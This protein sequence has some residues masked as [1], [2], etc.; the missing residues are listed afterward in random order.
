MNSTTIVAPAT[1]VGIGALAVVRISGPRTI[2]VLNRL[3]PGANIRRQPSHTLKLCWLKDKKGQP[4][5]QV[6]VALFRAPRSYTGEDMAEITCH[7]GPLIVDRIVTLCQQQGCRLAEPGEFTRRAVLAG[8]LTL[9]Q[10]EALPGIIAAR[11]DQAHRLAIAAYQGATS[12]F[13]REI[14]QKLQD[15]YTRAEYLLGFDEN[16]NPDLNR[17]RRQTR[18]VITLLNRAI[19]QSGRN[20]FLFE[21]A[22]VAIIGRPN[23]GKSSLFNRLLEEERAITSPIPGTTRDRIE[24]TTAINGVLITLIDTCGFDP[25]SKHPLTRQGTRQTDRAVTAAD[26]LLV[27]FDGSR[28]I[29]T[30][31]RAILAWSEKKPKI[32]IINKSDLVRRFPVSALDSPAINL[33]CKTGANINRLRQAIKNHLAPLPHRYPTTSQRQLAALQECRDA[34]Q[35]SLNA[36]DLETTAAEIQ[37]ALTALATI[38]KPMTTEELLDRVFAR[39]CVGK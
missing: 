8:K 7:G 23:V 6:M 15:L 36:P 16:D 4:V 5:D 10:A 14:S 9:S 30:Q 1:P 28:P 37:T 27:V 31:D 18:T 13:V 34:L 21:P 39:F 20:R 11:T 29:Q 24:A 12:R 2:I 33:S 25:K 19:K 22:R 3:L 17:L 32:Y 38:D 26:L 35:A